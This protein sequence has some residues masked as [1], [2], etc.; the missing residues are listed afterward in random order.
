M[1]MSS[2]NILLTGIALGVLV[3]AP[4]GPVNIICIQ[5]TLERGFMAGFAAGIGAVLADALIAFAAASGLKYIS[6]LIELYETGIQFVGGLILIAFGMLLIQ[7]V[8]SGKGPTS[9]DEL[10]SAV[11]HGWTV[12]QTF[13]LTMTNPGAIL[14]MFA[15]VGGAGTA[16]GGFENFAEVGLFVAAVAGGSCIWWA[17]LAAV[18]SRIRHRLTPERLKMINE[19]AG[20]SLVIFGLVLIAR[21]AIGPTLAAWGIPL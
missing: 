18:I 7:R 1:L 16:I 19:L 13:F 6:H 14:G 21:G 15:V 5:R 8:N 11:G 20:L 12:P 4:V 9:T 17:G 10:P 2:I 3:A